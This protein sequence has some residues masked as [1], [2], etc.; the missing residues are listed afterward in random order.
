MKRKKGFTLIELLAVIVILAIIALIA[1]PLVLKYIQASRDEARLRSAEN[2][3]NAVEKAVVNQ[4][5]Q[6][7]KFSPNVCNVKDEKL[8]CDG[9]LLDV[10]IKGVKPDNGSVIT[11][12]NG[13]IDRVKLLYEDKIIVDNEKDILVYSEDIEI[14]PPGLYD[15]NN[16]LLA[17]WDELV[18]TYGLN[19]ETNYNVKTYK[20]SGSMYSVLNNNQNLTSA[21]K[22]IVKEGITQIGQA[23]FYECQ[24]LEKIILPDSLISIG[25]FT[26]YK[27]TNL[28]EV[29]IPQNV[30]SIGGSAFSSCKSLQSID[31][32]NGVTII[33][34]STFQLCE[35]LEKVT[36][37]S[38]LTKIGA[39]A[40]A[41]TALTNITIPDN[42]TSIGQF[43]FNETNLKEILISKNVTSI[44][45]NICRGCENLEK[46]IVDKENTKYN[47]GNE[48]NVIVETATNKLIMGSKNSIIPDGIKT[49]SEYAFDG[50]DVKNI[51]IPNSVTTIGVEAFR[52]N[53][54]LKE[55]RI[56]KSV[57]SIGSGII[58]GC[59][60]LDK[61]VVDEENT[62]YDSRDNSNSIIKTAS[63]ELI[64]GCNKTVIP[65][66]VTSIGEY[67]FQSLTKLTSITIPNSVTNIGTYAFGYTGLTNVVIPDNV[68]NIGMYAF[69]NTSLTDVLIPGSVKS[70][71]YAAFADTELSD[72]VI[73]NGVASIDGFVFG[74]CNNLKSITIGETVTSIGDNA[75]SD[76]DNLITIYYKG[77]ATGAPWGATNAT[78]IS[79]Y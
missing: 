25:I 44:S 73:P 29:N 39:S 60:N 45:R 24:N 67:A 58:A 37:P 20:V 38:T 28:K 69:Y 22:V 2:Y 47:D 35:N 31:I 8:Y 13:K 32:P 74:S 5:M 72:V 70:I 40:F 64:S 18:N 15:D 76:S 30:T 42:V 71:G 7:K 68:T 6:G 10:S 12:N 43:V 66:T 50:L 56:P 26:F 77:T 21:T 57:T 46:V 3:V 17:S 61:I 51:N 52:N 63:N 9:I 53:K 33:Q 62:I 19:I 27:N 41:G 34:A 4:N 79:D 11:F 65:N 75:F 59:E 14:L 48:S 49:I 23:A 78:V 54:F 1:T 16:T 36:L 55:I